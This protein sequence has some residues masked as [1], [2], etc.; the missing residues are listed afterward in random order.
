MISNYTN[1]TTLFT[2]S[3]IPSPFDNVTLDTSL[4][5][6]VFHKFIQPTIHSLVTTYDSNVGGT[7]IEVKTVGLYDHIGIKLN[8]ESDDKYRIL[9]T[10]GVNTLV[11]N[12][13]NPSVDVIIATLFDKNN[14][15]FYTLKQQPFLNADGTSKMYR[16]VIDSSGVA[17]P[18][19]DALAPVI[20]LN[21]NAEVTLNVG[22]AYVE[23]GATVTD[24]SGETIMPMIT[25]SVDTNT[26][27]TYTIYYNATDSSGNVAAQITRR[28]VIQDIL[29]PVITLNGAAEITLNLGDAYVEQGAT[30][31][32]DSGETITPI[33]SGNV[34]TNAVGTYTVTYTATDSSGNT[35]VIH[36]SVNV[37]NFK[38]RRFAG[39]SSFGSYPNYINLADNTQGLTFSEDSLNVTDYLQGSN[40]ELTFACKFNASVWNDWGRI[41]DIN[42]GMNQ[43][44]IFLKT[45]YM[46][47][48]AVYS[49]SENHYNANSD[50]RL[51][52]GI[53]YYLLFTYS[54]ATSSF[55]MIIS[56]NVDG[57]LP[58]VNFTRNDTRFTAG[59]RA[60]WGIG[61][62]RYGIERTQWRNEYF[63]GAI[64]EITISNSVIP[65][66]IAFPSQ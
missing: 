3:T 20:T 12:G 18:I 32:D 35:S 5:P 46:G 57:S 14:T 23:L 1:L 8:S 30:V 7:S 25:G 41:I 58:V 2:S 9:W 31:T 19:G 63:E 42:N 64:T 62:S 66:N 27:G 16:T 44:E 47:T 24:N 56:E 55:T 54:S 22:D 49:Y 6:M 50:V 29:S 39:S 43:D 45:T 37:K 21:G 11:I 36:R 48:I 15:K 52:T 4:E 51:V 34:D 17:I 13:V 26:V 33:I 61:M 59:T 10:N 53:D 38:L 40:H 60:H 65:W 28:I